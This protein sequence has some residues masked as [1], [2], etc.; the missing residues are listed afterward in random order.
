MWDVTKAVSHL[1]NKA[2]AKSTLWCAKYVREAIGAGGL[3]LERVGEARLYGPSL[4]KAGFVETSMSAPPFKAGDVVVIQKTSTVAP[5]HMAMFNGTIWV[6][7]YRQTGAIYPGGS[8][9]REKPKFVVY[10][11]PQPTI[12]SPTV[13]RISKHRAAIQTAAKRE[14]VPSATVEEYFKFM[15][16]GGGQGGGLSTK[17]GTFLAAA[18]TTEKAVEVAQFFFFLRR[19]G[20]SAVD[21]AKI[22]VVVIGLRAP[23]ALA[24]IHH[25]L[26]NGSRVQSG[27]KAAGGVRTALSLFVAAVSIYNFC[28]DKE[29]GQ[30][31]AT[32]YK[33]LIGIGVPWAGAIDSVQ[34]LMPAADPK[35]VTMFKV[36]RACDPVGLGGAGIDSMV[37]GVQ[38]IIDGLQGRPFN[39][40][41]LNQLVKRLKTG[42]TAIFAEFGEKIPIGEVI[43]KVSQMSAHD[44]RNLGQQSVTNLHEHLRN[45]RLW[46]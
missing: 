20:F 22:F 1:N 8:F 13:A 26:K 10:R 46:R 17:L 44:W 45:F 28:C 31:A 23:R 38:A 39:D 25:V 9:A 6:S 4:K 19:F 37:F 12:V 34:S 36:L 11:Y 2:E 16:H 43:L 14:G 30:A 21:V 40:E 18:D 27:L 5:G 29:Y 32:A 3:Q 15:E 24:L 41:R 42:P 33:T 7:D 35:S